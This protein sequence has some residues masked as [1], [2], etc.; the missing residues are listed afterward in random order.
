MT[1]WV[2]VASRVMRYYC[3]TRTVYMLD[4]RNGLRIRGSEFFGL[5]PNHMD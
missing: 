2:T 4:L 1:M 5:I 3:Q